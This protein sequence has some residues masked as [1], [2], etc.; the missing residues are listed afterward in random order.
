MGPVVH[1]DII[2]IIFFDGQSGIRINFPQ[3]PHFVIGKS[4]EDAFHH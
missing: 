2:H 1:L 3:N 4:V